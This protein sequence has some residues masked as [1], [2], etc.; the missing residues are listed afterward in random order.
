MDLNIAFTRF[1][2]NVEVSFKAKNYQKCKVD[3]K[4]DVVKEETPGRR[5]WLNVYK[6]V[7]CSKLYFGGKYRALQEIM[8]W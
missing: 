6:L 5:L 7:L 8:V 4:F 3:R 2:T 1:T